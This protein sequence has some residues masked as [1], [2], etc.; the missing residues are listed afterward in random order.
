MRSGLVERGS[1]C[2][3]LRVSARQGSGAGSAEHHPPTKAQPLE[4]AQ[5]RPEMLQQWRF[6]AEKHEK[7]WQNGT[8]LDSS[9]ASRFTPRRLAGRNPTTKRII[10]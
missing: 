2:W 10:Q 8:H 5:A 3:D 7:Q 4:G 1:A 6:K 9:A